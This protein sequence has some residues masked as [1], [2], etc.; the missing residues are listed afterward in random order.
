MNLC[1]DT[2]L[3]GPDKKEREVREAGKAVKREMDL[4]EGD[5]SPIIKIKEP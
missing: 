5:I 1:M 4:F 3:R 2:S